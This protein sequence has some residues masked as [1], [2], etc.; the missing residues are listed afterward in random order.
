VCNCHVIVITKDFE[1]QTEPVNVDDFKASAMIMK[2]LGA[3]MFY[4][5][6]FNSGASILHKHMQLIPY[7]SL[8]SGVLPVEEA[9][10]IYL[11]EKQIEESMF[12]LPQFGKLPH[13]FHKLDPEFYSKCGTEEGLEAMAEKLDKYY[14]ECLER[15]NNL[16]HS[17]ESSYNL[18]LTHTFMLMVM[19]TH[20]AYKMGENSIG[21]N[22][23]GFGGTLAVKRE[24]DLELLKKM[25]PLKILE[26]VCN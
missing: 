19:R 21:V 5:S 12:T 18:L 11:K 24:Q 17:L 16:N 9:V 3:F 26:L 25:S 20:E 15:M 4:N 8:D 6:G 13:V 1:K 23:L 10:K 22:T 7:E 2:S 14:W